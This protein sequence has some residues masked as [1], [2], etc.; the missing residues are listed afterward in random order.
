MRLA[1]LFFSDPL[2]YTCRLDIMSRQLKL[3]QCFPALVATLF[4]SCAAARSR[5]QLCDL[6]TRPMCNRDDLTDCNCKPFNS[7]ICTR[8]NHSVWPNYRG[9]DDMED[10][11][12]EIRSFKDIIKTGCSP[13]LVDFLCFFYYPY[14]DCKSGNY[15]LVPCRN[16][17]FAVKTECKSKVDKLKWPRYL[18]CRNFPKKNCFDPRPKGA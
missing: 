14:C 9:Q 8:Y 10:A 6:D 11:E 7:T 3:V 12:V 18:A 2:I 17:C 15:S 5:F 16:F 13:Y 1:P 4:V